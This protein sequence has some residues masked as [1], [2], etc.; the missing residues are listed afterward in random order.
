VRQFLARWLTG[1]EFNTFVVHRTESN[2][3]KKTQEADSVGEE[4]ARAGERAT[5]ASDRSCPGAPMRLV[6]GAGYMVA[7]YTSFFLYH[8]FA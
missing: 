1:P 7:V 6:V 4:K 2:D 8:F 3:A 5:A